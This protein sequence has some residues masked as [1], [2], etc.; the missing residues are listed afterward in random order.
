MKW[1]K[2]IVEEK[3]NRNKNPK[4]E[5]EVK[6]TNIMLLQ[7]GYGLYLKEKGMWDK[8]SIG[9]RSNWKCSAEL[10]DQKKEEEQK[11]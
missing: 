6:S 10:R 8:T 11:V 5:F 2:A 3:E 1:T 9:R 7:G 4:I